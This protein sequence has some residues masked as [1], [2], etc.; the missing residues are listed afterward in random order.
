MPA[1]R[2]LPRLDDVSGTAM[3]LWLELRIALAFFTRIP[4]PT[5]D[6]GDP[7]LAQAVRAFPVVGL[8]IGF[9]GAVVYLISSMVNLSP[10]IGA[11]LAVGVMI[12]GTGGLH[13]DGLAD[14]ADG[15]GAGGD[16][17]RTLEVMRDSRIGTFGVLALILAIGLRVTAIAALAVPEVVALAL[18]A[19]GAGS[20]A[21]LPPVM[22]A[23]APARGDGLSYAAGTPE[24]SHVLTAVIIGWL[25]L[26]IGLGILGGILAILLAGAA[27]G[28]LIY[29]AQSRLGGQTGDVLG[30]IQQA[31]EVAILLAAVMA[32]T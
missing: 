12:V 13:E 31:T 4:I 21:C 18:L 2:H 10:V 27:G 8:I 20:R 1:D 16:R 15:L 22:Y 24:R 29:L 7:R 6:L 26:M 14:T 25:A 17:E 28:A 30:A 11:L 5:D 9:A 32:L 19:A 3:R 23:L